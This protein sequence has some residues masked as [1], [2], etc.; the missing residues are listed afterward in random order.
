MLKAPGLLWL[1]P[2]PAFHTAGSATLDQTLTAAPHALSLALSVSL[3]LRTLVVSR[4]TTRQGTPTQHGFDD[5]PLPPAHRLQRSRPAEVGSH[6]AVAATPF[7]S[8]GVRGSHGYQEWGGGISHSDRVDPR[9]SVRADPPDLLS[10]AL[11]MVRR[12][13]LGR[14]GCTFRR[15][16][17]LETQCRPCVPVHGMQRVKVWAAA[18]A[19]GAGAARRR[20]RG[21]GTRRKPAS[22]H[23]QQEACAVLADGTLN[24]LLRPLTVWLFRCVCHPFP[25]CCMVAQ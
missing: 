2:P 23:R 11:F 15:C 1:A 17:P 19:G 3:R 14:V 24:P 6:A 25:N 5:A 21:S 9:A 10:A 8:P 7:G 22:M 16:G 13:G 12:R 18:A 4:R 20:R